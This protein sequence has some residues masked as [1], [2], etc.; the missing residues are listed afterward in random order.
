[1]PGDG[2]GIGFG[3]DSDGG[4]GGGRSGWYGLERILFLF[5]CLRREGGIH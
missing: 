4:D 5:F 3:G 1:M 2:G